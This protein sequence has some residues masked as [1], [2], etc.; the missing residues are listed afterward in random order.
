MNRRPAFLSVRFGNL[1]ALLAAPAAAAPSILFAGGGWA[2]IDFGARCEAR[3]QP[4]SKR[5]GA[6]PVAGFAF[7]RSGAIGGRFYVRLSRPA[8]PGATVIA[9]IGSEPF[10]L[11]GKGE[12]A[13]SRERS[14]QQA[15]IAAARYSGGMRV[16]S[17]DGRGRRFVDRYLLSGAATA[18]DAAAATCAGA[19]KTS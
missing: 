11:A 12:W 13:W 4:L 7:D 19:G 18:I 5:K 1:A 15:M 10:L 8:R 16:E 9:T 6:D 3:S 2:A 17:R 14:Q